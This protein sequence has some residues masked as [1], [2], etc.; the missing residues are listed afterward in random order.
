LSLLDQYEDSK[1][2]LLEEIGH[3][4]IAINSC[5]DDI[6]YL[7]Q[8]LN[9]SLAYAQNELNICEENTSSELTDLATARQMSTDYYSKKKHR[10]LLME[11][12]L[13]AEISSGEKRTKDSTAHQDR[14]KAAFLAW[15]A[16]DNYCKVHGIDAQVR[17]EEIRALITEIQQHSEADE[18]RSLRLRK[19]EAERLIEAQEEARRQK[20][21]KRFKELCP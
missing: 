7:R 16:A 21:R 8:I 14:A 11:T 5:N 17:L 6:S 18:E 19:A 10:S 13:A 9:V 2:K 4:R 1:D 12:A 20:R 3:T 15:K